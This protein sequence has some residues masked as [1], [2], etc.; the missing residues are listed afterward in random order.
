VTGDPWLADNIS[1]YARGRP[2]VWQNSEWEQF[3]RG[4]GVL[5]WELRASDLPAI[6]SPEAQGPIVIQLGGSD[7]VGMCVVPPAD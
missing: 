2:R 3:R 7:R 6:S 1:L 5:V 4:G